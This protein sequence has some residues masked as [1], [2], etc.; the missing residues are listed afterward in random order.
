M[1][2]HL[3]GTETGSPQNNVVLRVE[4]IYCTRLKK[5]PELGPLQILQPYG[6]KLD[7]GQ[8]LTG[9]SP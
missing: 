7:M 3:G 2:A 6:I 1:S 8:K 9:T 4:G 5:M